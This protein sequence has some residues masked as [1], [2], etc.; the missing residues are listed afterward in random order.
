MR[1]SGTVLAML[2]W[3]AGAAAQITTGTILGT[4]TDTTGAVL[5]G[6]TVTI[7]NLDTGLTRVLVA[8]EQGRYREPRLPIGRYEVRAELPGF[9]TQVRRDLRLTVESEMVINFSLGLATVQ[10]TV[11]VVGGAPVVQ[12][13]STEVAALVDQQ[14]IQ[15]LPLNAR[16]IQQLAVLQAGVQRF[17]YHNFG[18]QMVVTGTRP[19][20][21]RFLQDGIDT[22]FTFTT[23]PVSAAGIIM[24]AEAVQEFKLLVGQYSAAYGEK[25]G[26]VVNTIT[27][28]GTN[29]FR[30]S[31]Y[32]FHR[33]DAMDARNYFDV[34]DNPPFNRNQFGVSLGG[35]IRRGKS[36]FFTNYEG[37]RQRLGLSHLAIVPSERARQGY[38]PDPSNPGQEIFV[39]VAPQ[40]APYLALFPRPNGRTF[41]DGTAEFFSNPEQRIREDFWTLRLDYG[42]SQ[43]DS[44]YGVVTIDRSEEFTPTQNPNFADARTYNRYIFTAQNIHTFSPR[45]VNTT[46]VGVN[47]TWYFFR[48]DTTVEVDPSLYF[49][50]NPFFAPTKIGQFGRVGITG[51][52][53]L[54]ETQTNVNITPR[55]FDYLMVSVSSDFNYIRGAHSWQFGVSYK[56]TWDDTVIANSAGRGDYLFQSLRDF[57]QGRPLQFSYRG[58]DPEAIARDWRNHIAGVY[59]EDSLRAS[60]R[61]TLNLGLRYEVMVGPFEKNGKISNLRSGL[62]DPAPT[63]G[64]PYFKQPR[65]LLAPRFGFNWDPFGDGKTSVRGGAGVFYDQI[66]TWYYFLQAPSNGPFSIGVTVPN[67]PFPNAY[68]LIATVRPVP[69]FGAVQFDAKAP[70]KYSYDLT[71]QRQLGAHTAVMVAYVG[72][73]SRH[74]GRTGDLNTFPPQVLPDGT[75]YWPAGLRQRPNPNFRSVSIMQFDANSFYD[76]FQA[77]IERRMADGLALRANYTWASCVDDVSN[78]FGGGS[79]SGGSTLQYAYD[80]K[81]SRGPCSFNSRHSFNMMTTLD[82][83][84]QNLTGLVGAV[85]GGWQW[86]TITQIQSG[87]PFELSTGFHNSRQGLSGAGPDRPNWAPGC[88]KHNAITGRPEQY[89]RPECFT[90]PP[91]GYLGNVGSRVL[92]GPGLVTS[93]WSLSKRWRFGGERR[94]EVRAE[95]FNVFNRANFAVPTVRNLFRPDG[96]RVAAAGAITQTVTPSRQVQLGIKYTF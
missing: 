63:V 8:D 41:P 93:D 87:V 96:S 31:L 29:E 90:L 95:V 5:P 82:L 32:E 58:P 4:V 89:F 88:D 79:L 84:G 51:L 74:L 73:L 9:Q 59:V 44:L 83:P 37:F 85:F 19:E 86:S 47:K 60:A 12:T 56:H 48:T 6:V 28:A 10:E 3:A 15:S 45:L 55:W 94:L 91:P 80:R 38:L 23:S 77:A 26:G 92:T 1:R 57:L 69:D 35:P 66:N 68:S 72:S 67:P 25:A 49:I 36:F 24:G 43:K 18:A 2:L 50:P 21:N 27:K 46:R 75:L 70:T 22:T 16:D 33:N 30:G 7:Q 64:Y 39:G 61:L 34:G 54:G 13:T 62:L 14:M 65:D 42:L 20:H 17:N 53:G 40:V 78:E 71:V 11:E 76:S 52:K 81:S